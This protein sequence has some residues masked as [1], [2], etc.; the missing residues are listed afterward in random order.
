MMQLMDSQHV[1]EVGVLRAVL[2]KVQVF[3]DALGEWI[4]AF[5]GV[6][7]SS[8]RRELLVQRDGVT[9]QPQFTA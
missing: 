4:L 9:V 1:G 5:G 8:K 6:V 3:W 7:V 2:L